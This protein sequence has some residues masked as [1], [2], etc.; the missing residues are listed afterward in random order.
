M[1][2][3]MTFKLSEIVLAPYIQMATLL[4]GVRR[5][6]GGNQ[7]RHSLATLA[8]LLD[9]KL[10]E[11]VLLK[12]S[13]IHDILED[14]KGVTEKDIESIDKDGPKV[15]KL[16]LEL[17]RRA[18]EEKGTYLK[19]LQ[20]NGSI[21]AKRIKCADRISNLTDLNLDI[22]PRRDIQAYLEQTRKYVIPMAQEAHKPMEVELKELVSVRRKLITS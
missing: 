16:V 12:A 3:K 15:L 4:I 13:V 20:Q 1:N 10:I 7:F 17:T 2:K 9:Y 14:V 8:I 18:D 22:R 21:Q 5:E 11:P 6:V 19:R